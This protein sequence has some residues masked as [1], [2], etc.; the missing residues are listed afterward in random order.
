MKRLTAFLAGALIGAVVVALFTPYSGEEVRERIRRRET[1]EERVERLR[2]EMEKL[3]A[4][5]SRQD[6][7]GD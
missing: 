1:P 2:R 6:A 7:G 3:E 4:K 5:L